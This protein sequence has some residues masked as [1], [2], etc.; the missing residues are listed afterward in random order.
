MTVGGRGSTAAASFGQ[1]R[2]LH[3]AHA[4]PT[5]HPAVARTDCGGAPSRPTIPEIGPALFSTGTCPPSSGVQMFYAL[6]PSTGRSRTFQTGA[7]LMIFFLV[8][9]VGESYLGVQIGHYASSTAAAPPSG[10]ASIDVILSGATI[11]RYSK[12][13]DSEES[14]HCVYGCVDFD[15][16]QS[17]LHQNLFHWHCYV[18]PL[19]LKHPNKFITISSFLTS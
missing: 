17:F 14:V 16:C 9:S 4:F 10:Y 5:G 6:D 8:N 18:S 11:G 13:K 15:F 12:T 19:C 2:T 3:P 1:V 7:G